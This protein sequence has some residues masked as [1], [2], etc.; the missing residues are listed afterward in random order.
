MSL[1]LFAS[2]ASA[3]FY[4]TTTHTSPNLAQQTLSRI[5]DSFTHVYRT[6]YVN[7]TAAQH[8]LVANQAMKETTNDSLVHI[9]AS[10]RAAIEHK[11]ISPAQLSKILAAVERSIKQVLNPRQPAAGNNSRPPVNRNGRHETADGTCDYSFHASLKKKHTWDECHF[12]PA[13]PN[14]HIKK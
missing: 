11:S 1:G 6:Q 3:A 9:M 8:H 14:N 5:V 2:I 13:N 7:T 10:A 4:T 12:N